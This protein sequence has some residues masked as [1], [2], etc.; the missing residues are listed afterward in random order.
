MPYL[1]QWRR[2]IGHVGAWLVRVGEE[3]ARRMGLRRYY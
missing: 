3:R 1:K 2:R